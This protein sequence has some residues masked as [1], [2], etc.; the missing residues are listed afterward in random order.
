M[1][2]SFTPPDARAIRASEN[3]FCGPLRSL[4]ARCGVYG[5]CDER[6]VVRKERALVD[7]PRGDAGFDMR[8]RCIR[9]VHRPD[10]D[11]PRCRTFGRLRAV[12]RSDYP[13]PKGL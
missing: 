3:D 6:I 13:W 9:G 10:P 1:L 5:G 11:R 8:G 7:H 4:A 2:Q 12:W